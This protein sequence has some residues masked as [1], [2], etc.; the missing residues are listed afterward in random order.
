MKRKTDH[1]FEERQAYANMCRSIGAFQSTL[2][3]HCPALVANETTI[4]AILDLTF[5]LR[6]ELDNFYYERN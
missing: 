4:L 3:H 2:I 5:K 6:E 1:N